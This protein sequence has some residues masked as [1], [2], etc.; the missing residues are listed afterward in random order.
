MGG[1]A[2]HVPAIKLIAVGAGVEEDTGPWLLE[3]EVD[4]GLVAEG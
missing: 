2:V 1:T 4:S 3:V